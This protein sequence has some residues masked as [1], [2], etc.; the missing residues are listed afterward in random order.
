MLEYM[1]DIRACQSDQDSEIPTGED[2]LEHDCGNF[3]LN[4]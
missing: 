1:L 3:E 4:R 2:R